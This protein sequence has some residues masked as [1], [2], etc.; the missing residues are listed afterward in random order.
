MGN[1][2]SVKQFSP[3]RELFACIFKFQWAGRRNGNALLSISTPALPGRGAHGSRRPRAYEGPHVYHRHG[4]AP[5]KGMDKAQTRARDWGVPKNGWR[6]AAAE[7]HAHSHNRIDPA[8]SQEV[9]RIWRP[10]ALNQNIWLSLLRHVQPGALPELVQAV[11][12]V[13]SN[14]S[15]SRMLSC[16]SVH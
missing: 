3:R 13:G 7:V 9:S 11:G 14:G 5:V 8:I 16:G 10:P 2:I 12:T 15:S 4:G 6:K 1:L